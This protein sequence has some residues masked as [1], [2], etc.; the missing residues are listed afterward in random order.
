MPVTWAIPY[1]GA[2]YVK[3]HVGF[4]EIDSHIYPC[5]YIGKVHV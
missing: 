5:S 3:F 4:C 1:G 2:N